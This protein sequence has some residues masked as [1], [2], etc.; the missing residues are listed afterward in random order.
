L[1]FREILKLIAA[2][3]QSALPQ[4]P[5]WKQI[6]PGVSPGRIVIKR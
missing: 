4:Q 1:D 6:C 2:A 3:L 5:W